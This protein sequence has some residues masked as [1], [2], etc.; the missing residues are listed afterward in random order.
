MR[1]EL[2]IG[3]LV[4]DG[5][6]RHDA[7]ALRS[8]LEDELGALLSRAPGTPYRSH[9]VRRAGAPP[10]PADADPAVFG[11]RVARAVHSSLAAAAQPR[12]ADGRNTPAH[13]APAH[14]P[15]SA[16]AGAPDRTKGAAR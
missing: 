10:V 5:V 8:A 14:G 4:L 6:H 16:A 1:I 11:R 7:P 2:R 3:R 12:A 15:A 13:A 9:R